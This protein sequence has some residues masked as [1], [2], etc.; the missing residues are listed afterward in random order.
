MGD[1]D[2]GGPGTREE[3]MGAVTVMKAVLGLSVTHRLSPFIIDVFLPVAS[4]AD[5]LVDRY[6]PCISDSTT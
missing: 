1:H 6:P 2:I 3:W 4:Q 5:D